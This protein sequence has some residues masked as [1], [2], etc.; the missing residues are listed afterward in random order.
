M[1]ISDLKPGS[2]DAA[3]MPAVARALRID[4][5][6]ILRSEQPRALQPAEAGSRSAPCLL[7]APCH[8][9]RHLSQFVSFT[10]AR[11]LPDTPLPGWDFDEAY[12][13]HPLQNH[14]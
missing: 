1:N 5:A 10:P 14:F 13:E 7:L 12:V 6:E 3:T 2:K 11:D 9:R 8:F 4:Q